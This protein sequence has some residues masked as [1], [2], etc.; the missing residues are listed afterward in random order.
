[1][2]RRMLVSLPRSLGRDDFIMS[3]RA[4]LFAGL[5]IFGCA[6]DKPRFEGNDWNTDPSPPG[7]MNG[8]IVMTNNGDDTLSVVDPGTQRTMWRIP[9]GFIPVELEGPHHVSADPTGQFLYVNLSEAVVN[10]GGGPH[11]AHGTGTQP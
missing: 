9:I 4:L 1:M 2:A 8:H 11:G 5:L 3:S 6:E 10:S 7:P